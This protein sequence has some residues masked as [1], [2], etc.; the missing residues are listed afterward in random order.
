MTTAKESIVARADIITG[1]AAYLVVMF[2]VLFFIVAVARLVGF[3]W[4]EAKLTREY[5]LGDRLPAITK[6]NL[7]DSTER[8]RQEH[9]ERLSGF[10]NGQT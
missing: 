6:E 5:F 1:I 10:S 3:L 8:S 2:V 4:K 9:E 7:H